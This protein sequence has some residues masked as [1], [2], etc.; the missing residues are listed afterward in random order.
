MR[1]ILLAE[2]ERIVRESIAA[3]L[4]KAG[5]SVRTAR[6]GAEALAAFRR[7]KPDLAI[8]DVMMPRMDGFEVCRAI[9][10]SDASTPVL[11]LTALDADA[12]QVRGLGLGADDYVSKSVPPDV[13]LARVAAALR[14]ADAA[15]PRG[16]FDFGGWRVD[17]ARMEARCGRGGRVELNEREL[18]ILRL[19]AAHPGEVF[20]R[21]WLAERFWTPG[22][23]A[24]DNLLNVTVFRLRAKLA[25]EGRDIET[26]RG[27]G[28]A[29]RPREMNSR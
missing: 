1:D 21:D 17:A 19:F 14:R 24:S 28:Y 22:D 7:R 9:R 8:L 23:A 10:E 26:V 20:M 16:G 15:E 6:N 4:E 11:F 2:D 29:Y 18:A 12:A 25:P 3:M 5:H 27:A 13:L